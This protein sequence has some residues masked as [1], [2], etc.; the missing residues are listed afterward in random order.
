MDHEGVEHL[1]EEDQDLTLLDYLLILASIISIEGDE[2]PTEG[3][4]YETSLLGL[5]LILLYS[6]LSLLADNVAM[7]EANYR[8]ITITVEATYQILNK[9]PLYEHVYHDLLDSTLYTLLQMK[10]Y[11]S[12]TEISSRLSAE[13]SMHGV[14][15]NLAVEL[16]GDIYG[17]LDLPDGRDSNFVNSKLGPLLESLNCTLGSL[18][19]ALDPLPGGNY[20]MEAE[21]YNVHLIPR[22]LPIVPTNIS[23]PTVSYC[24]TTYRQLTMK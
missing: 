5:T 9:L 15:H 21:L 11:P 23:E 6:T 1:Y 4:D 2:S 8:N 20:A 7:T 17:L 12:P 22:K 16:V 18:N 13:C 14:L 3:T 24:C 19:R 10:S